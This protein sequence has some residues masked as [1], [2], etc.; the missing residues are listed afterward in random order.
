[1]STIG[2]YAKNGFT[3]LVAYNQL[4]AAAGGFKTIDVVDNKNTQI[5]G[6]PTEVTDT[7]DADKI[8]AIAKS[9]ISTKSLE[10]Y[11]I[12]NKDATANKDNDQIVDLMV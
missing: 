4:N 10:A 2:K 11:K 6:T 5:I 7:T 3:G 8:R 9:K 1:M 12:T